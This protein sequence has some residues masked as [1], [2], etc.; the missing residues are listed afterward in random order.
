MFERKLAFEI[1]ILV[2]NERSRDKG[3]FVFNYF[4]N[5]CLFVCLFF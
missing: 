1:R 4:I 3:L 2:L 5:F